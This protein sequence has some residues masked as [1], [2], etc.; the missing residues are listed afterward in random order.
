MHAN[1]KVDVQARILQVHHILF[2]CLVAL[3]THLLI[4]VQE[5]THVERRSRLQ[6]GQPFIL[7]S[8]QLKLTHTHNTLNRSAMSYSSSSLIFSRSTSIWLD[9]W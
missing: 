3:L 5:L 4:E 1:H 8:N 7:V 6:I 2:S 9:C